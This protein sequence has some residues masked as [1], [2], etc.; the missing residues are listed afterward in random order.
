ME[1]TSRFLKACRSEPLDRIPVWLM[2]QAGRYLPEYRKVRERVSF[3]TLCKTPDLAIEVTLQPVER[4]GVDAAILFSDILLLL[5]AMG[6]GLSF[7]EDGG[8]KLDPPVSRCRDVEGL[9]TPDPEEKLGFVLETVRGLRRSLGPE[10]A[11]VGF[12]GAPF[13]LATYLIEGGSS[14]EFLKTKCLMYQEPD[15][16]HRLLEHLSRSV[17]L[18]AEAQIRAGVQAVQLFDTWAGALSPA[19][20]EEYVA[21]HMEQLFEELGGCGV[22]TIHFSLGTSTL[23]ENM[24]RLGAQV[25][26]L[27]WK[28]EL[29]EA[30]T[31]LGADRPVQGNLD[32][33]AL[34]KPLEDLR[35]TVQRMLEQG[36]S[37][38]GYI[39][40]LGH[41]IHPRTPVENV[42]GL[43]EMVHAFPVPASESR[44]R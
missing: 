44:P 8:P 40:N 11:L 43:V 19:D 20:Y 41:G 26:S 3:L 5:E 42:V 36:S 35:R 7:E 1:E 32:P 34:F 17:R 12:S 30:R 31:R 28:M 38:P 2:R 4:L 25:L 18:Y 14:R 39:F 21:P 15:A 23:M 9:P 13:T 10:T 22:P 27:D 33:L 16:F 6:F 24:A 29:G 37:R